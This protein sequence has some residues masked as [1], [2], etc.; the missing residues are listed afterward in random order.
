M[1]QLIIA[2]YFLL[3]LVIFFL[4]WRFA[5]KKAEWHKHENIYMIIYQRVKIITA[6]S[7]TPKMT[8]RT[9]QIRKCRVVNILYRQEPALALHTKRHGRNLRGTI[10]SPIPKRNI[11]YLKKIIHN[12]WHRDFWYIK[13]LAKRKRYDI[14]GASAIHST[15]PPKEKQSSFLLANKKG[16]V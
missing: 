13:W 4:F 8:T 5:R 12:E 7:P 3:L 15:I 9:H 10:T 11:G 6:S 2:L 14:A 1:R 16:L